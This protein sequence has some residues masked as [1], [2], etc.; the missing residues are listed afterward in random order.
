MAL[1]PSLALDCLA[2]Q[3]LLGTSAK[4]LPFIGIFTTLSFQV[5]LTSM[6]IFLV[7][8]PKELLSTASAPSPIWAWDLSALQ[9][10][11]TFTK[12]LSN[13]GIF[14]TLSFQV[15]LTSI[16]IFLVAS[17]TE[18]LSTASAPIPIW[19]LFALQE[20]CFLTTEATTRRLIIITSSNTFFIVISDA[21]EIVLRLR[22]VHRL[23]GSLGLSKKFQVV[24]RYFKILPIHLLGGDLRLLGGDLSLQKDTGVFGC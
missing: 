23:E 14:A 21:T 9:E 19:D 6:R 7:A 3:P 18:F 13:I 10:C 20:C 24:T 17:P 11:P 5:T 12:A 22:L 16:R 4:A 8:S 15:P 2:L 1:T